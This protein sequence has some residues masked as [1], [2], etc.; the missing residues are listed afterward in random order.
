MEITDELINYYGNVHGGA[1]ASLMDTCIGVAINQQVPIEQGS[2]TV[3]MKLNYIRPASKGILHGQASVVH[4]GRN[5][6]VAYGEIMDD[7]GAIVAFGT[8]TFMLS[9]TDK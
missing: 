1:I 8:A 4:K 7:A 3:E 5:I 2:S 6:V 9:N